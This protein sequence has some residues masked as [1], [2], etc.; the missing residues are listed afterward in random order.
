MKGKQFFLRGGGGGGGVEGQK[1]IDIRPTTPQT[2][3][4][5][6][7][8]QNDGAPGLF[9]PSPS[10]LGGTQGRSAHADFPAARVAAAA[11]TMSGL[12][13]V[14]GFTRSAPARNTQL[15]AQKTCPLREPSA[16]E[17]RCRL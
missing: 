8:E 9:P 3:K 14:K 10:Q 1:I 13:E 6:R 11:R 16:P 15:I 5:S 12:G 7:A 2:D 4:F 17:R